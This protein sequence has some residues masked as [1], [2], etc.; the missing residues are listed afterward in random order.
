MRR[1]SEPGCP[2]ASPGQLGAKGEAPLD[3]LGDHSK[4]P[5]P[6]QNHETPPYTHWDGYNFK[7]RKKYRKIAS[8]DGNVEKSGPSYITGGHVKWCSFYGNCMVVP[9]KAKHD[10]AMPL[11]DMC[12]KAL[13]AGGLTNPCAQVFAQQVTMTGRWKQPNAHQP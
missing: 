3:P 4:P 6:S 11:L 12:P 13:R 8:A 2:I 1:V 7:K 5:S 10:P 9:Q